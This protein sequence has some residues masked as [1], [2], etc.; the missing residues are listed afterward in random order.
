[1]FNE[2]K[3]T[4]SDINGNVLWLAQSCVSNLLQGAPYESLLLVD[5]LS[6]V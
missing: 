4:T 6:N 5:K 1:M 2:E 3:M